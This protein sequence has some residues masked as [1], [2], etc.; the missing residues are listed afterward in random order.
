MEFRLQD[1]IMEKDMNISNEIEAIQAIDVHAHFGK[2]NMQRFPI[3]NKFESGTPEF[4]SKLAEKANTALTFVSPLEGFDPGGDTLEANRIASIAV[5]K[6]KSLRQWVVITPMVKESYSQARELLKKKNCI[7]VKILPKRDYS[8]QDFGQEI[9]E[10]ASSCKTILLSHAGDETCRPEDLAKLANR[11]PDVK[12]I[13]AHLG[14]GW[15][16]DP[17]HHIRAIRMSRYNNVFVDTSSRRSI[18]SQLLEW[19][20]NEIGAEK[21]LYGTDSPLYFAPMQRAR[22]DKAEINGEAKG[23]ILRNNAIKLFDLKEDK[24]G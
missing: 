8:L 18:R 6:I 22:I 4:V 9:F 10:F 24:D 12:V 1:I 20:V 21:I 3:L 16:G 13:M 17:Y 15:D 5:D 14:F 19:A 11:F 7:G 2:R 23:M